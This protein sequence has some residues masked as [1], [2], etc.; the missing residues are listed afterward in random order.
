MS[1]IEQLKRENEMMRESLETINNLLAV[2]ATTKRYTD[3]VLK[4][5]SLAHD[6]LV[7]IDSERDSDKVDNRVWVINNAGNLPFI[8]QRYP[9]ATKEDALKAFNEANSD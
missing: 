8:V 5:M 9:Y 2:S 7:T 6:T 1:E 4:A 3:S